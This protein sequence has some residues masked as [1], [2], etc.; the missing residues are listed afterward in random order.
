MLDRQL[1]CICCRNPSLSDE[2]CHMALDRPMIRGSS[3]GYTALFQFLKYCFQWFRFCVSV[4]SIVPSGLVL[5][6]LVYYSEICTIQWTCLL[7][8]R[9]YSVLHSGLR[10]KFLTDFS[11]DA[12]C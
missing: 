4:T 2:I 7:Y 5:S 10:I 6:L 3:F 12:C 1:S 11:R 9:K 8:L